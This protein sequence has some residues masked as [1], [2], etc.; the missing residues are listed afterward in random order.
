MGFLE[1]FNKEY[2]KRGG[3]RMTP[4][5]IVKF[6]QSQ[7]VESVMDDMTGDFKA[8]A[9]TRWMAAKGGSTAFGDET[10]DKDGVLT[11]EAE[12]PFGAR[13]DIAIRLRPGDEKKATTML[14][15]FHRQFDKHL[16]DNVT[17]PHEV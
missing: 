13:W 10:L 17:I 4:E 15:E 8:Q 14:K 2:K 3:A 9:I 5:E 11:L 1:E 12:A 6:T 7:D 16:G